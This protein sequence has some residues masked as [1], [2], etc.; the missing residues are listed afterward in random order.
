[1]KARARLPSDRGVNPTCS[2]CK[3][4]FVAVVEQV[5]KPLRFFWCLKC[6]G[7]FIKTSGKH[8]S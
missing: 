4:E 1:M 5:G 3:A 7:D 6:D 8:K 2:M